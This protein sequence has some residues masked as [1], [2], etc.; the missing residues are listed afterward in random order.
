[1]GQSFLCQQG[2]FWGLIIGFVIGVVRMTVDFT[3]GKGRLCGQ[4][5]PRPA[6]LKI[7]FTYFALVLFIFTGI[8]IIVISLVTKPR[9]EAQVGLYRLHAA[10]AENPR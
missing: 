7:H 8:A 1:M 10:W 4:P 2:A 3:Y 9:P 5:D 6:I